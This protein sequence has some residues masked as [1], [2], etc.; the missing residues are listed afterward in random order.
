MILSLKI[1]KIDTE[2]D[3][4]GKINDDTDIKDQ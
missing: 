1:N 3:F 4:D 2:D